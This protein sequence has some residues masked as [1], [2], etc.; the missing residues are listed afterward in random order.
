MYNETP[1]V[2]KPSTSED[3]LWKGR[4]G[5][6]VVVVW[7]VPFQTGYFLNTSSTVGFVSEP[8]P[9]ETLKG[10]C[11][12]MPLTHLDNKKTVIRGWVVLVGCITR[13]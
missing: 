1:S 2:V 6:D 7:R 4:T 5:L 10:R 13:K 12:N 3:R 9:T 11:H 8:P